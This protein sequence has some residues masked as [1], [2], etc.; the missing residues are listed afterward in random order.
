MFTFRVRNEYYNFDLN[1]ADICKLDAK[2]PGGI[3]THLKKA[4]S[5]KDISAMIDMMTDIIISSYLDFNGFHTVDLRQY[6]Q[7]AFDVI[8]KEVCTNPRAAESFIKGILPPELSCGEIEEQKMKY[9]I[10]AD[11]AIRKDYTTFI[12]EMHLNKNKPTEEFKKEES[13][14]MIN[15]GVMLAVTDVIHYNDKVTIVKYSDGTFTKSVCSDNDHFD[16]DVGITVCLCKKM[17]GGS[18]QYNNL[19]RRIHKSQ[20]K[21]AEEKRKAAAEKAARRKKE[22][23]RQAKKVAKTKQA[24]DTYKNDISE[25]VVEALKRYDDYVAEVD[26]SEQ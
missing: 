8:F 2:Y 25:A 17:L 20:E 10:G 16:P 3:S 5:A 9:Y 23:E 22:A 14:F 11:W 7:H 6:D 19:I 1:V 24:I 4:E 15:R 26:K 21:K 18:T 12:K 13:T